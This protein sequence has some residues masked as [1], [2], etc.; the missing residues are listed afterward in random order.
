MKDICCSIIYS[1]TLKKFYTRACQKSLQERIEKHNSHFYG[2]HKYT[3]AASD[4]ELFLRIDAFSYAHALR[5]ERK[6]KS[7]K[8]SGYIRNLAKYPEMVQ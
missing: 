8:S 3:A 1:D 5:I 6:T 7:M 4:W 2:K